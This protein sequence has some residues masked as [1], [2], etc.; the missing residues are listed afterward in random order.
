MICYEINRG[1]QNCDAS[2]IFR[3][4]QK[5]ILLNKNDVFDFKKE[6]NRISFSLKPQKKGFSFSSNS[7]L[8]QVLGNYE[9]VDKFDY[10]QFKHNVQVPISNLNFDTS[11]INNGDIFVALMNS[12]KEVY[13]FGFDYLL[14]AEPYLFEPNKL[15]SIT[16]RS[17]DVGLEDNI[18][19]RFVSLNPEKDFNENFENSEVV[20]SF[21][22]FSDDFNDDF[23]N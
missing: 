13:I 5:A 9:I 22:Q 18:P 21:G 3:W 17:S 4:I 14:Q 15:N 12:K 8:N 1:Q 6:N 16:L 20:E 7:I 23:N 10:K 2:Y 19:L 11:N